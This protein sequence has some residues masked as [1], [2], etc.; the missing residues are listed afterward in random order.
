MTGCKTFAEKDIDALEEPVYIAA[1]GNGGVILRGS[2]GNIV[3]LPSDFYMAKVIC[4]SG[5]KTGDIFIPGTPEV[6]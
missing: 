2:G 3:N 5:L 1:I 4:D 6:R